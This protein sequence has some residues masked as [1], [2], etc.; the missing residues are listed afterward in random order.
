MTVLLLFQIGMRWGTR[1]AALAAG[2]L[3]VMPM[4]VRESHFV[5]ADVP[6]TFF[7][8]LTMLLSL[9]AHERAS[10]GAFA[11]AGAA[12]GLAAATKYPGVIALLLPL[13][14][15][16][17]TMGLR[18]SRLAGVLASCACAGIAFLAAAPYTIL[19]L[20][21]FLNGYAALS[22]THSR[23]PLPE[24]AWVT[25]L[26]HLR[27]ALNWP[28]LL[29]AIAGLALGGVRAVRGP[30]RIRWTLAVI[31]PVLYFWFISRQ[32]LILGRYLLPLVPFVCLLAAAAV[33]SGVSLL[34]RFDIPR[35][36][37]TALI[38]A[39]T[40]AAL[41][42]PALQSIDFNVQRSRTAPAP[43]DR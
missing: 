18:P 4:H 27:I 40:V 6:M 30:G 5:L 11:W 17:M 25:Y 16:W 9:R 22:A 12:A 29:M 43:V 41:L 20:P 28:A 21:G 37:R 39:L 24:P 34:R 32:T 14:A 10:V 19:D 7:V 13:A 8:T 3:A 36:V 23:T 31:F 35:A 1:Y 15:A 33:V 26:K 38:A 42:P 2:L